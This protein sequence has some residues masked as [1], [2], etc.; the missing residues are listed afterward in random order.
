MCI[1]LKYNYIILCLIFINKERSE[2]YYY[3]QILFKSKTVLF[4][5]CLKF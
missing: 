3:V 2:K 4:I 1:K 5:N